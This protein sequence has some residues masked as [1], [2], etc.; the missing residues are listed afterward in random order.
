MLDGVTN[1]HT[2]H[3]V[4]LTMGFKY[5]AMLAY[6]FDDMD[7]EKNAKMGMESAERYHGVACGRDSMG[8]SIWAGNDPSKGSRTVLRCGIHVQP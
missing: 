7:F 5:P 6:F 2:H 3:I 1:Y 8:T 4:N